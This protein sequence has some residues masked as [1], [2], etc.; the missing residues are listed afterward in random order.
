MGMTARLGLKQLFPAA[1][2]APAGVEMGMTARLGLKRCRDI[3]STLETICR[4]GDD[5]PLGIETKCK[6]AH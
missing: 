4:N 3:T 5:S 1:G 6:N 2:P